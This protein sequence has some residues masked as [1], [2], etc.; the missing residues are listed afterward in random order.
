MV[1]EV[2]TAN[3]SVVRQVPWLKNDRNHATNSRMHWHSR[4][5]RATMR[6]TTG[7]LGATPLVL[8]LEMKK[9]IRLC[10][11][12]A[13]VLLFWVPQS[14]HLQQAS[15]SSET[16]KAASNDDVATNPCWR[17]CPPHIQHKNVILLD[18]Y[19]SAGFSDREYV[20][21]VMTNLAAYLCATVHAPPPTTMVSTS[22]SI[23]CSIHF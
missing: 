17:E 11:L 21:G 23:L 9:R 4:K 22:N 20:F 7:R 10:A 6:R 15:S 1:L 8:W 5:R 16:K 14:I 2:S 12:V 13:V 3:C 18:H 19:G